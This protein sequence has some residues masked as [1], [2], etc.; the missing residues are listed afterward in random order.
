M[1]HMYILQNSILV[2]A[3]ENTSI[4]RLYYVD[5]VVYTPLA[6]DLKV[7]RCEMNR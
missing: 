3:W 7:A 4:F 1:F 5:Y 2:N 6:C